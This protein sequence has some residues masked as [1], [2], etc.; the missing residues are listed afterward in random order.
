MIFSG[1]EHVARDFDEVAA[2]LGYSWCPERS[3]F[4]SR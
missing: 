4:V 1:R 3:R 2:L